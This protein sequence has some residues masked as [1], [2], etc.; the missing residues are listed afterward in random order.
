MCSDFLCVQQMF[1][2]VAVKYLRDT[3][4]ILKGLHLIIII[5]MQVGCAG[6]RVRDTCYL[7]IVCVLGGFVARFLMFLGS[8]WRM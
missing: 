2:T 8:E 5:I 6:R 1:R 3:L 7:L 4:I